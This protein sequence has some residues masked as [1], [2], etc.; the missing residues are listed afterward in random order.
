[1]CVGFVAVRGPPTPG[2]LTWDV[3]RSMAEGVVIDSAIPLLDVS[4]CSRFA[5]SEAVPA[6]V[7]SVDGDFSVAAGAE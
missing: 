4:Q 1:M 3:R 5:D 6:G 2:G 7:V